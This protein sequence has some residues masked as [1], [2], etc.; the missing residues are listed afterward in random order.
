MAQHFV[1]SLNANVKADLPD[2]SATKG[3]GIPADLIG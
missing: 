2:F 1:D 3:E